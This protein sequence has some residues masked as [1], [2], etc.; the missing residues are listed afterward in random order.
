VSWIKNP[1]NP[2]GEDG[3]R[4]LAQRHLG[5]FGFPAPYG[6]KP[7][8][9]KSISFNMDIVGG[10]VGSLCEAWRAATTF[11]DSGHRVNLLFDRETDALSIKSA[12]PDGMLRI[13]VRK[14]AP[15]V[16]RLPNWVLQRDVMVEGA[17]FETRSETKFLRVAKPVVAKPIM[18]RMP[19]RV[20]EIDLNHHAHRIKVRLKGDSIVAMENFGMPLTYFD[21]LYGRE[22]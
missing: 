9:A 22:A 3:K 7:V 10:A 2:K 15:L 21:Q 17:E 14:S 13:E 16:V 4:D 5:S 1:P 6:H 8:D 12:Y 20:S 18:I 19:L 11:D